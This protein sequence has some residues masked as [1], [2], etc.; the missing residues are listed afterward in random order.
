MNVAQPSNKPQIKEAVTTPPPS[1]SQIST[2]ADL[3]GTLVQI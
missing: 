2:E 3:L 1:L